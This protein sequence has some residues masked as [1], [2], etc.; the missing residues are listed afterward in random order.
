[1]F[2]KVKQRKTSEIKTNRLMATRTSRERG[3][4]ATGTGLR[5][6]DTDTELWLELKS[7]AGATGCQLWSFLNTTTCFSYRLFWRHRNPT[8]G[9]C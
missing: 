9:R 7:S 6:G 2:F 4:T 8:S 5:P 1:M 3:D